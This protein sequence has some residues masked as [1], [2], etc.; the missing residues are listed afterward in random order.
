MIDNPDLILKPNLY[1]IGHFVTGRSENAW[2]VPT[3]A[4]TP[5]PGGKTVIFVAP[6]FSDQ[7]E[8][9]MR[10]V[11]V[12]LRTGKEAQ[13]LEG[14]KEPVFV[15]VAGNRSLTDGETVMVIARDGGL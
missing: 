10:D 1:V 14:I 15:V 13:I 2:V 7:G 6:T 9:E 12:G 11:K 8:A 5:M 4:L 3:R